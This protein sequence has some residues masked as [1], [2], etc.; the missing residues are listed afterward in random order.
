MEWSPCPGVEVKTRLRLL[1]NGHQREHIIF[2]DAPC[3]AYDCGAA[4]PADGQ[5]EEELNENQAVISW[6]DEEKESCQ[7]SVLQGEGKAAVINAS[8]NTNLL[9]AKTRIPAGVYALKAG[10]NRI[11]TEFLIGLHGHKPDG[12]E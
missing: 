2:C 6:G 4:V 11:K 7:V 12:R 10:E 3:T 5:I 1:E 8:P 9:W